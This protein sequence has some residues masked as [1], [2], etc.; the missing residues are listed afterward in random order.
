[1]YICDVSVFLLK[2]LLGGHWGLLCRYSLQ[3]ACL[4]GP[5]PVH[6]WKT[7]RQAMA[8]GLAEQERETRPCAPEAGSR[9]GRTT[10]LDGSSGGPGWQEAQQRMTGYPFLHYYLFLLP[11]KHLLEKSSFVI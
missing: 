4:D 3:K 2:G 7:P 8:V 5:G 10:T 1:M 9:I 6:R 11:D